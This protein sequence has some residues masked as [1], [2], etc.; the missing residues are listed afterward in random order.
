[1]PDVRGDAPAWVYLL[2]AV[3]LIVYQV[4]DERLQ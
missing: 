3:A 4:I 1:M 2:N